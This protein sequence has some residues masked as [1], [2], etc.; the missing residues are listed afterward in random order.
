V[1]KKVKVDA[2]IC[3]QLRFN[4]SWWD[5]CEEHFGEFPNRSI[6]DDDVVLLVSDAVD[7]P[8]SPVRAFRDAASL[9]A[10]PGLS[11]DCCWDR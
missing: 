4:G 7:N 2:Y 11:A 1:N 9:T 10:R 6:D 3:I 5:L 8:R